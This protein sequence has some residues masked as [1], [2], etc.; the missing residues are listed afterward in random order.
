MISA[1]DWA[2]SYAGYAYSTVVVEAI[3]KDAFEHAVKCMTA[4]LVTNTNDFLENEINRLAKNLWDSD[5][6]G[7]S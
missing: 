5:E 6:A 2:E 1:R 4:I 3:Q 7:G